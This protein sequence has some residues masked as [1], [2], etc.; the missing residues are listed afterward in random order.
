MR[1]LLSASLVIAVAALISAAPASASGPAPA[2]KDILS[3]NCEGLG[4]ITVSVATGENSNGA[5]QIVGM[6]G[7]GI[8][9]AFTTTVTDVTTGVEVFSD[10][11]A[12]GKGHAHPNQATVSCSFQEFEGSASEIFGSDLPPGVAPTDTILG[13]GTVDVILKP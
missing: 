9:V 7:H 11:S 6:R 5:G 10:T 4:W 3:I 1:K 8:P 12:T 2:G 13:T